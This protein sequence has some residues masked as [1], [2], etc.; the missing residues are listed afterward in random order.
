LAY[1]RRDCAALRWRWCAA[2]QGIA[3]EYRQAAGTTE[4]A[5]SLALKTVNLAQQVKHHSK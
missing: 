3:N 5:T 1:S 4:V 2:P